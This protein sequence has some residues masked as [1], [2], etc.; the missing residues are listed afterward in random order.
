MKHDP[1][2]PSQMGSMEGV[3]GVDGEPLTEWVIMRDEFYR[4]HPNAHP[5]TRDV[6]YKDGSYVYAAQ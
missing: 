5:F 1:N 3:V 6:I 4:L 2:D